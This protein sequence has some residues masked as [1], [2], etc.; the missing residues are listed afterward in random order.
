MSWDC[1]KNATRWIGAQI[2]QI[3]VEA[4]KTEEEECVNDTE[5]S[6]TLMMKR[7]LLK[8]IGDVCGLVQRRNLF[9]TTCKVEDKHFK[10]IIDN[11]STDNFIST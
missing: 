8:T 3:E 9:K 1:P 7:V 6:E 2:L 5:E 11:G 10:L 4:P